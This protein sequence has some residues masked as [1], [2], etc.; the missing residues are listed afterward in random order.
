MLRFEDAAAALPAWTL[1]SVL[2]IGGLLALALVVLASL[3]LRRGAAATAVLFARWRIWAAT[4]VAVIAAA[5]LG[6]AG[7]AVLAAGLGVWGAAEYTRLALLRRA[8]G[9]VL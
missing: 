6:V 7:I 5:L 8:D 9:L 2:R 4:A 3:R 1:P